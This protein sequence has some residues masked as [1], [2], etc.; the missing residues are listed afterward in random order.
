MKKI[1]PLFPAF[2]GWR[3][4][5][6]RTL[7][8]LIS[9]SGVAIGA[10]VLI[11]VLSVM[12]GF[13]TDLKNRLLSVVPHV[14]V[15]TRDR[16]PFDPA[17]I[18]PLLKNMDP[19]IM[20]VS[21]LVEGECIIQSERGIAGGLVRGIDVNSAKKRSLFLENLIAG[22]GFLITPEKG[23]LPPIVLGDQLAA[24]LKVYLGDTV[25]LV[26]PLE[27]EGPFGTMPLSRRFEVVG[28]HQIGIAE[29]D[30]KYAYLPLPQ[31]QAFFFTSDK[32]SMIEIL[33]SDPD[34]APKVARLIHKQWREKPSLAARPWREMHQ[35]LFAALQLEKIAMFVI[36]SCIILVASF[37]IVGSLA[38]S[39]IDRQKAISVLRAMGA[40]RQ[41]IRS[42]FLAEGCMIGGIGTGVGL[43][44]GGLT[45]W[46]LKRYPI[47][48]LPDLYVVRTL[49]VLVSPHFFW[50]VGLTSLAIVLI[51]T[52]FPSQAASKINP[53]DGIRYE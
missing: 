44:V 52:W 18:L 21:P 45:C 36:L 1:Y 23:K 39:V 14:I 32:V 17:A 16:E 35:H 27:K 3:Y 33:L 7:V 31:A 34:A 53:L 11:I 51:A 40:S 41:M 13:G 10:A 48:E 20:A 47:I 15:E 42:I 5:R 38:M 28:I 19:K 8:T 12:N 43:L 25:A 24:Q 30:A 2:V 6:F 29:Y 49:P 4:F 50:W 9:V 46:A 37:N 22:E 26:S